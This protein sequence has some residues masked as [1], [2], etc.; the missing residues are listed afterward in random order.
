MALLALGAIPKANAQNTPPSLADATLSVAENTA[1]NTQ[2]TTLSATDPDPDALTYV[3]LSGNPNNAFSL[4]QTGALSVGDASELDYETVTAFTLQV[5]VSDGQAQDT[6]DIQIQLQ[7]LNDNAPTIPDFSRNILEQISGVSLGQFAGSDADGMLDTLYYY[8]VENPDPNGNGIGVVE[9]DSPATLGALQIVDIN[10]LDYEQDT[11]I[12]IR[13]GI[14]DSTFADT[15]TITINL[16]NRNDNPA[17]ILTD[18]LFVDEEP[19]DSVSLGRLAVDDADHLD[20]LLRFEVLSGI[21]PF[22]LRVDSLTG[23]VVIL[24]GSEFDYETINRYNLQI[25]LTDLPATPGDQPFRD[26]ST[27]VIQINNLNDNAPNVPTTV[28][29]IPE[30]FGEN[31]LIGTA[32]ASDPD[33]DPFDLTIIGGNPNNLLSMDTRGRLTINDSEAFD[34]EQ[35]AEIALQVEARDPLFADTGLVR[36]VLINQND[37]PPNVRDT[38]LRV[39]ENGGDFIGV[40]TATDP[41]DIGLPTLRIIDQAMADTF[42][43]SPRGQLTARFPEVMD[44]EQNPVFSFRVEMHDGLFADTGLVR[45]ELEDINDAPSQL[46]LSDTV[47]PQTSP[48]GTTVGTL[49][50][51]DQDANDSHTFALTDDPDSLLTD[52]HK[53][54]IA[55]NSLRALEKFLFDEQ[56]EYTVEIIAT[57]QAGATVSRRFTILVDEVAALLPNLWQAGQLQLSPVPASTHL[58]VQAVNPLRGKLRWQI[59]STS[60]QVLHQ[61]HSAKPSDEWTA[62]IS[63]QKLPP[64]TYLLRLTADGQS[65]AARF[66]KH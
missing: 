12:I 7:N 25:L 38:V 26:T 55:G 2:I 6:A 36:I 37:N 14:T 60:G 32:Q 28:L 43:V 5:E 9:V 16:I 54:T 21:S 33:G 24:N 8:L 35:Y 44:F 63:L 19:G 49:S 34:F 20:S 31:L 51:A 30:H 41:D 4:S 15:A 47:I 46:F 40:L 48:I 39:P 50:V 23:E 11:S 56:S 27:V 3:I 61:G 59:L 66:V 1:N 22:V 29:Q 52:N 58:Q 13:L 10:D 57:D 18:T 42:R 45:I 62:Q 53:F 64:G 17:F 65:T